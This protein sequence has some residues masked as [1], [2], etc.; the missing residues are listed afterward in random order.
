MLKFVS[1]ALLLAG[2]VPAIAQVSS[3]ASKEASDPN[4]IVCERYEET[5][6]RLGSKKVCK[7]VREWEEARTGKRSGGTRPAQSSGKS[8]AN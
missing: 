6:S 7:T 1:A 4:K 8:N 2:G 3:T 5:G